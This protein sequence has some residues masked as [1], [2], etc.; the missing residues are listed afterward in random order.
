MIAEIQQGEIL[1]RACCAIVAQMPNSRLAR[2]IR[3]G[4]S[5]I[6]SDCARV[7]MLRQLARIA[8]SLPE[9][10]KAVLRQILSQSTD[11]GTEHATSDPGA[12]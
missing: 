7:R 1:W 3:R 4:Y 2:R 5:G 6:C 8:Q 12:K 9:A 11:M 10:D